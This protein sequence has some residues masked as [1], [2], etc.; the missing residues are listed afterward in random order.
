MIYRFVLLVALAFFVSTHSEAQI[1]PPDFLCVK[2]D[3]LFW[4]PVNNPCGPFEQYEIYVSDDRNGP[5]VLLA[6]ITDPNETFFPNPTN[7]LQFYYLQAIHDCPGE[8]PLQSD[9]LNNIPP[10]TGPLQS[11]SVDGSNVNLN[12]APSTSPQTEG[13]IIYRVTDLGTIP[14]DTV[15]NTTTYTDSGADPQNQEETYFVVALDPCGNISLFGDPHR[16]LLIDATVDSCEQTIQLSWNPYQNWDGG[17]GQTVIWIG[18]NGR[19]AVPLDTVIGAASSYAL[20]QIDKDSTYCIYVV[21]EESGTNNFSGSNQLCITPNI[22]QPVRELFIENVSYNGNNEIAITYFWSPIAD[23]ADANLLFLKAGDDVVNTRTINFTLPLNGTNTEFFS[24]P[25]SGNPDDQWVFNI[26]TQDDCGD[27]VTSTP[28][29]AI[30]LTALSGGNF[31]NFLSWN[32]L[33]IENLQVLEYTIAVENNGTFTDIGTVSGNVLEYEHVLDPTN[34]DIF[35]LCYRI[36]AR[37]ELQLPDGNTKI[38]SPSYSNI[39]CAAQNLNYYMPNAF[40][41]RGRNKVF[42]PVFSYAVP[43]IFHMQVYNRYG[44]VVFETTDP[45]EGWDGKK[46][47]KDVPQGVYQYVVRFTQPDG[48]QEQTSGWV[49]LVR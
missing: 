41:P 47:G 34:P 44:G 10:A 22:V 17:I 11:V 19:Q 31:S 3:T 14:I 15:F 13:Y 4:E 42:K 16:T 2:S 30:F 5:Y 46:D 43:D 6:I 21:S 26:D 28:G 36:E 38:I 40:A 1:F 24:I 39:D 49:M 29:Q 18:E 7:R 37:S 33:Q 48:N 27:I 35:N 9:T 8:T 45:E 23:L 32:P 25:G 12:W 20:Q